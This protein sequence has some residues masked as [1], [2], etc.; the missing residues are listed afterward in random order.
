MPRFF[1][2][3][4]PRFIPSI[5]TSAVYLLF[6]E[7]ARYRRERTPKNSETT[8]QVETIRPF[9]ASSFRRTLTG[10]CR[11]RNKTGQ[12]PFKIFCRSG[13]RCKGLSESWAFLRIFRCPATKHPLGLK[14]SSKA[15]ALMPPSSPGPIK[16]QSRLLWISP[17][18]LPLR[19]PLLIAAIRGNPKVIQAFQARSPEKCAVSKVSVFEP[20]SGV[21][22]ATPRV[23]HSRWQ[24]FSSFDH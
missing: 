12:R 11:G 8:A 18:D 4:C 17:N 16:A 21:F 15:S 14:I 10:V 13:L 3:L 7:A 19:Y 24:A 22:P 2:N 1:C 9:L 23:R 6:T 5:Y 20:F